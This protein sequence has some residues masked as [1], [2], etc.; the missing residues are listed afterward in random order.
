MLPEAGK[1]TF[2]FALPSCI[3]ENDEDI[4]TLISKVSRRHKLSVSLYSFVRV[5]EL[6]KNLRDG[7]AR[8]VLIGAIAADLLMKLCHVRYLAQLEPVLCLEIIERLIPAV[9]NLDRMSGINLIRGAR[10]PEAIPMHIGCMPSLRLLLFNAYCPTGHYELDMSNASDRRLLEHLLIVNE[11]ERARAAAAKY[12]DLSQYG[13][14]ECIRNLSLDNVDMVWESGKTVLPSSGEMK[15]DFCSPFHPSSSTPTTEEHILDHLVD[16]LTIS[17]CD[18]SPKCLTMR[19]ML[20]RLTLNAKQCARLTRILPGSVED[21]KRPRISSR[22]DAFTA[23]YSRCVDIQHLLSSTSDGLYG[24]VLLTQLE[25]LNVRLRLGRLRTWDITRLDSDWLVPGR[26]EVE[27][28]V[29]F[30]NAQKDERQQAGTIAGLRLR[31]DVTS[32]GNANRFGLDLSVFEE[33]MFTCVMMQVAQRE[34]GAHF[35]DPKWSEMAHLE[36]RGAKWLV[37]PEWTTKTP[38]VGVFIVRYFLERD[39]YRDSEFRLALAAKYLGW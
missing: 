24:L 14:H 15:F 23:L 2:K 37:P 18:A 28:R 11:W 13:G 29:R 27:A 19:T 10:G 5:S 39:E 35:D 21:A 33:W 9:H 8:K 38:N 12:A 3:S 7:H 1:L 36:E 17:D 26:T 30:E 6:F 25:V 22:V 34:P 16:A 4:A 20:H 32:R 31:D